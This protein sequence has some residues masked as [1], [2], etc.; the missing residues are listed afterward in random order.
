MPNLICLHF[1]YLNI[2]T[3][4]LFCFSPVTCIHVWKSLRWCSI[5]VTDSDNQNSVPKIRTSIWGIF[6]LWPETIS[7]CLK[8][9]H[10]SFTQGCILLSFQLVHF[11]RLMENFQVKTSTPKLKVLGTPGLH[12]TTASGHDHPRHHLKTVGK[13]IL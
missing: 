12:D 9:K 1:Y 5:F 2:F 4:A 11:W 13:D 10:G 6:D 7:S 3:F 8:T